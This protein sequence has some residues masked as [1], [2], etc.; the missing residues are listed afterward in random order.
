MIMGTGNYFYGLGVGAN[1]DTSS[2]FCLGVGEVLLLLPLLEF[3]D[4]VF[5]VLEHSCTYAPN[6][7]N[8]NIGF[9]FNQFPL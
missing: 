4:L 2:T 6:P 3:K 9:G 1:T 7:G 5:W 8:Y